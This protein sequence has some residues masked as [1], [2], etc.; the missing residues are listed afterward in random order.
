MAHSVDSGFGEALKGQAH[1]LG[2]IVVTL[3]ESHHHREAEVSH[4]LY[5]A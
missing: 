5:M 1:F 3:I 4:V 2:G